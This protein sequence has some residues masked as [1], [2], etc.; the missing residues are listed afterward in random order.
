MDE[1]EVEYRYAADGFDYIEDWNDLLVDVAQGDF[2]ICKQNSPNNA[3]SHQ[4]VVRQRMN[5]NHL[6]QH[7]RQDPFPEPHQRWRRR[8]RHHGQRRR[9]A[10][11]R[12][13]RVRTAR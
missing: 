6:R 13:L 3:N 10:V 2:A 4:R 1:G 11:A 5:A 7:A 12:L 9:P 8:Q